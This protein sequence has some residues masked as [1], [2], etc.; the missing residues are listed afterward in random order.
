MTKLGE[1]FIELLQVDSTNNYALRLVKSGLSVNGSAIFA[2]E[3]INGRGQMGKVWQTNANENIIMSIIIDISTIHLQN[4]FGLLAMAALGCY[5]FF[6]KYTIEKTAIKW[7]N[8]LYWNDKKAGGILIE[9]ITHQRKRYAIIGI[10]IN[11]NQT[12]FDEHLPNPISLKQITG[13]DFEIVELAKEV[14][15]CVDKWY[16]VLQNDDRELLLETYNKYL[17]K[18]NETG[19]LK[20][21]NIKF[22][23]TIKGVNEFGELLVYNGF[24][25]NFKFGEVS[26]VNC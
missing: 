7:S 18:K 3:Q 13:K 17:Y 8:D 2:R 6:T 5:D 21:G 1:P 22:N 11:I 15:I 23:G 9:T 20:K 10:G 25:Q 24:E 26:F 16:Q 14:C 19:T 12:K 4:Q